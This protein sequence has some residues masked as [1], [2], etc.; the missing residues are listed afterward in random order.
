MESQGSTRDHT[1]VLILSDTRLLGWLLLL[2]GEDR[3]A[4]INSAFLGGH[5]IVHSDV[6]RLVVC[7]ELLNC[8]VHWAL[9]NGVERINLSTDISQSERL[10]AQLESWYR[11]QGFIPILRYVEMRFELFEHK[12]S[13]ILIPREYR[14][15][16]LKDVDRAD[17]YACY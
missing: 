15:E 2:V 5:P 1:A 6:D 10:N 14:L 16:E 11:K 8:A 9:R 4:E 12:V 13:D 7:A 17:L 3:I